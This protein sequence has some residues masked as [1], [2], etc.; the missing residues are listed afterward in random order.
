MK[1]SGDGGAR[2]GR[3]VCIVPR[4]YVY[5]MASLSH[6]LYV[7]ATR[8]LS[9]RVLQHKTGAGGFTRRYRMTRLVY[10]QRCSD[11]D[12][13]FAWE[14]QLKTWPREHKCRLIE[15]SNPGWLDLKPE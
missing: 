1:D 14:R 3:F 5:I 13:A 15:K 2:D 11:R 8:H 9:R 12:E 6:R 7:G 10:F 4:Y